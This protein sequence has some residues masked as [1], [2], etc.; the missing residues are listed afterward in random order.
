MASLGTMDGLKRWWQEHSELDALVAIVVETLD[1]GAV[2]PAAES[3][4]EFDGALEAHFELEES[5]YFLLVERVS[6][7]QLPSIAAARLA[8]SMMR[9]RLGDL[10]ALVA[11]GDLRAARAGLDVVLEV[12]RAHEVEEAK[13]ISQ[14]EQ[15]AAS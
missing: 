2:S 1:R 6:P 10:R 12:F 14:L 15:L 5:A 4:E 11:K 7:E 8:H 13:L 3:L 9:K